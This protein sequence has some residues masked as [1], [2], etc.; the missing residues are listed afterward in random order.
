MLGVPQICFV[1]REGFRQSERLRNTAM[2]WKK[3]L[4]HRY[5]AQRDKERGIKREREKEGEKR[6]RE[7]EGE[8]V[9]EKREGE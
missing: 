3:T 8:K 4:T 6:E 2:K 1:S 7:R 5:K 9:R